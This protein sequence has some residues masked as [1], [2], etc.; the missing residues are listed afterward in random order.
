MPNYSRGNGST[1]RWRWWCKDQE[2]V[3][4]E[5]VVVDQEYTKTNNTNNM[6]TAH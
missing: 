4:V 3:E 1:C 6:M 5:V 2:V